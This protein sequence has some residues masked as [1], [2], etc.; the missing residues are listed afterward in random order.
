[1]IAMRVNKPEIKPII[2]L[3]FG[4]IFLAHHVLDGV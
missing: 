2:V 4:V 3:C 1:M